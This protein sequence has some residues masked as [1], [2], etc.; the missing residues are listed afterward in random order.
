MFDQ[1]LKS[2]FKYFLTNV[3]QS[4]SNWIKKPKKFDC[5]SAIICF[6]NLY[7]NYTS[8]GHWYKADANADKSISLVTS[9]KI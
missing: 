2:S 9:L 4:N 8:T 7:T 6:T 5:T 3:K 1:I